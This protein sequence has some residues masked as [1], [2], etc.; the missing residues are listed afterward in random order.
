MRARS[1]RVALALLLLALTVVA[2]SP[3]FSADTVLV[4]ANA[5]WRYLDNGSDQGTAWRMPSFNDSAWAAGQAELGYGDGDE[6]TTV[7]YGPDATNKYITTYFRHAFSVADPSV[8]QSL[9]LNVRRDDGAV[10][11]LNGTE[12]FRSNMPSGSITY[13]T[14]ALVAVGG[15]D[16][17][18][19]VVGTPSPSLL[20]AGT[21]VLAVEIHQA[22]A[23]SSDIS[24]ALELLASGAAT[25]TRGP[26]L[27]TGTP[28]SVVVRWRTNAVTDGRVRYGMDAGNLTAWAD[29]SAFG[30]AHEV[31]VS[32]LAPNTRYYYSVGTTAVSLAGGDA[33]YFFVTAPAPGTPKPTRVWVLGDS[34]TANANAA[35]VRDAYLA[36]TGS[37]GTDLWLMLGDNAYP[38]GTD[39]QYQSA[40]FNMYPGVLRNTVLW[41]TLGN[42]DGQ[43]A[44]SATQTGPYYDI[45]TLPTRGEAGGIPSGTEAY[46][47]F[48]NGNIHFI[49]LESFETD[50]SA[51]G[52][53]LTWLQQ[54]LA[55][56]TQPWV[57]AFWHH[58]PYSKGSHDSD[59]DIEMVQMREN[60][61]PILE[62][63]GVD[64]VLTGHS[65]SYERSFL[66]DGH[67][68]L[69][70]T[71]TA[72]MKKDGGDGRTDGTGAYGKPTLGPAFHEGAV[73]AVAGSSGQTGGGA[74]N[75]PAMF[76]S[77]NTLGSMVLDVNGNRL[78]AAFVDSTGVLRDYFTL[79]KGTSGSPPLAPTAVLATPGSASVTV[80]FTP[81]AF[82]S[83]TLINYTADCG[84]V[85]NTGVS[86]PITV[87]GLTNGNSYT[88]RVKTTT[89]VGTSAWSVFSNAVTPVASD[90]GFPT[91][92]AIP[93]GWVQPSGSSAP[94]VVT[95]DAVYAGTLSLKSGIIISSQKSEVSYTANFGAG[96][97]SFARKVSSEPNFD[98]LE[99]YIDGVL[100]NRWSGELDW[101][102][103]SFPI[104]AGTHTLLWRFVKNGSVTSGSDAAWIDSVQLPGNQPVRFPLEAILMLLLE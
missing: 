97:V 59:V 98:F 94:W 61:L 87:T 65:H 22:N 29:S 79:T 69:S 53:M 76:V 51:S 91:G 21:N 3:T 27:Q 67:Y 78:D 36:Y 64:L 20:V 75:H 93:S 60:A 23:A 54:D 34:G 99:F 44:D 14:L 8:Y 9:T 16:E 57:I 47:S 63:G 70:S 42:H 90:D 85:T 56:T 1:G 31:T 80:S 62:A 81:G 13:T 74:L 73:Y 33:S 92:G 19:Y 95:N 83:G 6:A 38:D 58:P 32:G 2:A 88:C 24:F 84:G 46:Y 4:P 39:A 7:G 41:P 77:F 49:V 100:Q 66:I 26:Y 86:S 5:V 18:T 25:V 35:A 11:Y 50:R 82:G 89:T 68:G 30:T 40:V 102:V 10:V 101:A 37:R 104:S 52:P 96:N 103:V 72:A 43:S 12:V 45:F 15:S 28:T 71:F 55:A 17:T 48:D